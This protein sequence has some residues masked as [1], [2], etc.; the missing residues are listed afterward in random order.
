MKLRKLLALTLASAMVFSFV[1][2]NSNSA[3]SEAGSDAKTEEKADA[4]EAT[5]ES[6]GEIIDMTFFGAMPQAEI[7]DGNDIQEI[8]AE[9]TGVRVKETWLTGQTAQEAVGTILA[10]GEYPDLIDGGDATKQLYDADALVPWDE[11]LEK[12][13]NLK[14]MFTDEEWDMF[15]QEDGKI[16]WANVFTNT[17]GESKATWHNDEAFWVQAKVLEEAGYPK[18]ETL[19]EYFDLLEGYYEKHKTLEDGT[20]I[21]PYTIL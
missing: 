8:I 15:R 21:I 18:I 20:P 3:S 19:D 7:N 10:S 12:Y 5:E 14:E 11:Y 4:A 1:G 13:P 17:Y 9:K 6:S 16:Y 2:C